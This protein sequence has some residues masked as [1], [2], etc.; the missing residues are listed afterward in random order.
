MG[1]GDVEGIKS[2]HLILDD[3]NLGLRGKVELLLLEDN[4]KPVNNI[5][6]PLTTLNINGQP[7]D[8]KANM[9]YEV[10]RIMNNKSNISVNQRSEPILNNSNY[11][12]NESKSSFSIHGIEYSNSLFPNYYSQK[13]GKIKWPFPM[14]IILNY[15]DTKDLDLNSARDVI[16]QNEKWDEFEQ[17]LSYLICKGVYGSTSI[18][19]WNDFYN[20]LLAIKDNRYN[21]N[22]YVGLEKAKEEITSVS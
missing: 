1:R 11:I 2:Y 19:Y 13:G 7:F 17:N 16:I 10:G 6:F 3:E 21:N 14:L 15:G 4:G 12:D 22:F 18:E 8:I 20:V 9:S 5:Q